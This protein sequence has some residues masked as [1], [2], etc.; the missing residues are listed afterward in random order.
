VTA[1]RELPANGLDLEQ[2]ERSFVVQAL[3]RSGG[4]QTKA[5]ALLGAQP[6]PDSIPRREIRIVG[7]P[8]R[9]KKILRPDALVAYGE[10]AEEIAKLARDRDAG[11]IVIG[12]HVSALLGARMGSVT[13]RV[14]CLTSTLVLSLPPRI[15]TAPSR[16]SV[17]GRRLT[18]TT[19]PCLRVS[20]SFTTFQSIRSQSSREADN[21]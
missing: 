16:A 14:L 10:P 20:A 3:K 21:S 13:Y 9:C 11:L 4:N 5:A 6:G 18:D 19:T 2:L 15:A 17:L 8:V 7:A 1:R 12:L